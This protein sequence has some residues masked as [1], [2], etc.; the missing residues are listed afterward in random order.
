MKV[1][2]RADASL[3]IGTGHVMRC[4]TLADTLREHGAMVSF[5][6]RAHAGNL[7]DTITDKGYRV[8]R[9]ALGRAAEDAAPA[10]ASWLGA[11]WREDAEA[12]LSAIAGEYPDWLI[13]DHYALDARWEAYLRPHVGQILV[14]DDLADRA[15]NCELLLDQNYWPDP[16]GRYRDKVP[17]GCR[18]LLGPDYCLLRPEF[19]ALR[20]AQPPKRDRVQ[21]LLVCYGGVDLD[22]V[23]L[24]TLQAISALQWPNGMQTDVVIG[25]SNPHRSALESFC[26]RDSRFLLHRQIDW[27]QRLMSEVDLAI[28]APGTMSWERC[29]LGLPSL[30]IILAANQVD[31]ARNL[32][33]AGATCLIGDARSV[34]M[35]DITAAVAKLCGDPA[36][37]QRMA[38][39]AWS[40]VDGKGVNRVASAIWSGYENQHSVQ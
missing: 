21:R 29:C 36:A 16:S 19:A 25:G 10:H 28:G 30:V 12:T 20:G 33:D 9:L 27:I 5:V 40:L 18:E 8:A 6:C 35:A 4:L 1:V 24:L 14:I 7:I 22:N 34:S 32:R 26:S 15:H 37:M 31:I 17:A 11:G 39:R 2:I 3:M 23:T 13:V 38:E